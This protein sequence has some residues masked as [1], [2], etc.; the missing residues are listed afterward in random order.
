METTIL[1]AHL[2]LLVSQKILKVLKHLYLG[3]FNKEKDSIFLTFREK[4]VF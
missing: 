4:I 2:Y 1:N 3:N